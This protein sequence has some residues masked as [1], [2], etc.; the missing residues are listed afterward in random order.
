MARTVNEIKKGM[1]DLWMADSHVVE[2]YGL[3]SGDTFDGRFPAA[4]VESVLFYV[5]AMAVHVL[6]RIFDTHRKEV[7][8]ALAEKTPHTVA[9]YRR[10]VL[11]FTLNGENP[12]TCC[13]VD[14]SMLRLKIKIAGGTEGSRSTVPAAA[15]AA[16][17]SYL[18]QEKDA[19][20]KYEIVN[21][22]S[23]FL[24]IKA[25][26]WYDPLLVDPSGYA[27]EDALKTYVSGYEFDGLLN[28]NNMV[29]AMRSVAGVR[30]VRISQL[31]TKYAGGTFADLGEQKRPECGYWN[32]Q[33]NDMDISYVRYTKTDIA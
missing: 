25:T 30:M 11:G 18:D 20:L 2:R 9:C 19:G 29:E 28:R 24:K 8:E 17:E 16:L 7:E 23:N 10:L 13:S 31:Q 32:I 14:D 22:N 4:S 26:V 3:E 12:V 5:V 33:D 1:T 27:V 15:Q 6:E 21:E